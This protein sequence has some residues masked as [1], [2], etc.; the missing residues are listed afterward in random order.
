MIDESRIRRDEGTHVLLA[1]SL[2]ENVECRP[3]CREHHPMKT[4]ASVTILVCS[5]LLLAAAGPP[6]RRLGVCKQPI[7]VDQPVKKKGV[8]GYT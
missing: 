1:Q 2:Q 3:S 6:E 7:D 5:R 8:P 4:T